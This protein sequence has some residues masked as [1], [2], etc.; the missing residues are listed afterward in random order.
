VFIDVA[1]PVTLDLPPIFRSEE[2]F[3]YII[4]LPIL[5]FGK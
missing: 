5:K 2:L 3:T 4:V 1:V